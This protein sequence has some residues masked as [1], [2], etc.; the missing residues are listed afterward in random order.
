MR[1]TKLTVQSFKAIKRAEIEFG[2]ALNV[3]YGPNDLGKSTIAVAIR[4]ALLVAPSST[5][6]TSFSSWFGGDSPKVE[7]T[8][9][10]ADER[11]W[12]VRKVFG[13]SS[14]SSAEL[15]F[16]KD[17]ASFT[18][19]CKARQ[20]EEKLREMLQWGVPGPGGKRSS[21]S[22]AK[23]FLANVLIAEQT[24]ADEVLRKSIEDDLDDSG[25]LR[26]TRA[27]ASLAQDPLF[28]HVLD[29]A[30]Q[31]VDRFFTTTGRRKRGQTSQFKEAADRVAQ[32]TSEI[33]SLRSRLEESETIEA[34][35]KAVR[36][37]RASAVAAVDDARTTLAALEARFQRGLARTEAEARLSNAR[38]GLAEIDEELN[39][40]ENAASGVEI[41]R[42][43]LQ[44][45]EANLTSCDNACQ[46]ADNEVA[47]A[48]EALRRAS[49]DDAARER[50]VRRAQLSER[51]ADLREKTAA[52]KQH[53][54][55]VE[56]ALKSSAE[57]ETAR[58]NEAALRSSLKDAIAA[59]DA[60][61][62]AVRE[63]TAAVDRARALLAYVR[64]RTA[65]AEAEEVAKAAEAAAT[66]NESATRKEAEAAAV[67]REVE[68][69]EKKQKA[70]AE[71][72]PKPAAWKALQKL[73]RELEN[74][75]AA[76]GGG[77]SIDVTP[78]T[79][80]DVQTTVDGDDNA[81]RLDSAQRFE[82]ERTFD[83]VIKEVARVAVTA[84]SAENRK[85]VELLRTRW[86]SEATPLLKR[87]GV[88]TASELE[89]RFAEDAQLRAAL[90]DLSHRAE[91]LRTEAANLRKEGKLHQTRAGSSVVSEDDV[92]ARRAAVGK[93]YFAALEKE[94][95][96]ADPPM[97]MKTEIERTSLE[98]PQIAAQKQ[99]GEA[100]RNVTM[101]EVQVAEAGKVVAERQANLRA[102]TRA[103]GSD[104]LDELRASAAEE[105]LALERE[106][107]DNAAQQAKLTAEV[108]ANVTKAQVE[109]QRAQKAQAVARDARAAALARRD[110]LRDQHNAALGALQ[111]MRKRAEKLDRPSAE[112]AVKR[113]ETELAVFGKDAIVS[114]ADVEAA[115]ANA[116]R[117]ERDCD[118]LK[119]EL[120]VL[121]GRLSVVGGAALREERERLEE[122]RRI[123][124]ARERELE[125][126]A[127]AWKLLHETLREVE[128]QEGAHLGRALAVPVG[129]SFEKLTAG[130]YRGLKIDAALRAEGLQAVQANAEAGE[131]LDALSVGTRDQLAALLR[132]A[133]AEQLGTAVILDDHLV[134]SDPTRL[135]WFREALHRTAIKSQVIVLTCRGNDYLDAA[136]MSEVDA[137]TDFAGGMIRAINGERVWTRWESPA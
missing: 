75:E 18:Q 63:K 108:S 17:G 118:L 110:T 47:K 62:E 137:Q 71:S 72:L 134:H 89:A 65:A 7:L 103:L 81:V 84:G 93:K 11:Y 124:E 133:I 35:I 34:Q 117:A 33:D 24:G 37:S 90:T 102:L 38:H 94:Y 76:L 42:Q 86:Q 97:E 26:L 128:N 126:D 9:T 27:L 50:E 135:A 1:L 111:E 5:E 59:R 15:L 120:N 132:L 41:L 83:L 101:A 4:A 119:E 107:M 48:D 78:L 52:A 39:Q 16:S 32:L 67:A 55:G 109:L 87:A 122:A 68:R 30:Q 69:L 51:A 74:A 61:S 113:C 56:A 20:V 91:T 92:K 28:K 53:S 104:D 105:L 123:A 54:A 40:L 44:N 114:A 136:D 85:T 99:L 43:S 77:M 31:E 98:G 2:R 58:A 36:E 6:A 25:R 60:A 66:S 95:A 70:L 100:E 88:A 82:A 115:K 12:K 79:A 129:A 14:A 127:D 125:I 19:D 130:R 80:I 10:D 49:S 96:D 121:E 8:F 131:V 64:W 106:Q 13:S 57:L 45:A 116:E 29:V 21:S 46:S 73:D 3:V 23:S 22:G 112:L